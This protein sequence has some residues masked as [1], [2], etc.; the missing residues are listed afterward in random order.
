MDELYTNFE[1]R[2]ST[3][4]G[5][6]ILMRKYLRRYTHDCCCV[7]ESYNHLNLVVLSRFRIKEHFNFRSESKM[8][9]KRCSCKTTRLFKAPNRGNYMQSY[10]NDT[11]FEREYRICVTFRPVALLLTVITGRY[12][13][14][15]PEIPGIV[16]YDYATG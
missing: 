2:G 16:K 13:I 6:Q 12:N 9:G 11:L 8:N 10:I 14:I 5:P 15:A 3:R 7:S 4:D 1:K